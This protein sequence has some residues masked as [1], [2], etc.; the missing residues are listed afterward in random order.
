M[1]YYTKK[2]ILCCYTGADFA[3]QIETWTDSAIVASAMTTLRII[4]GETIPYPTNHV[5][6]RWG[7][8]P[9]SLGSYTYS[10]V[11]SDQPSD[12]LAMAATV[13]NRLFFAGEATSDLYPA[14]VVG[15]YLSGLDVAKRV[16]DV[17]L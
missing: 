17:L 10:T 12:R 4:Y 2:P 1:H 5:L 14:T 8:D 15:A 7:S 6:S 13:A 11:G 3:K 16:V 9:Y